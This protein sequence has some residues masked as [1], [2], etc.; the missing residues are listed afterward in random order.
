MK[1][2]KWRSQGWV[3]SR[4]PLSNVEDW[5]ELL[6]LPEEAGDDHVKWPRSRRRWGWMV[7]NTLVLERRCRKLLWRLALKGQWRIL[8]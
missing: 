5:F 1:A 3:D 8:W 2:A 4:G 7:V 6:E